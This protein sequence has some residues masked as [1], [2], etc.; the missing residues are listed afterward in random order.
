MHLR[1]KNH[2]LQQARAHGPYVVDNARLSLYPD[3]TLHVQT[4]R[5]SFIVMKKKLHDLGL[6]YSLLF[7]A[8]VGVQA[9]GTV[10]FFT[11]PAVAW[12][13]IKL[14]D[15]GAVGLKCRDSSSPYTH[16]GKR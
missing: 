2:L 11:E 9:E 7:P 5:A 16:K 4:Q 14:Y 10:H 1:D 6:L 3:F 15:K 8:R 12:D 13:L